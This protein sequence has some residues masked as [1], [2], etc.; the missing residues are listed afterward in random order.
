M[1]DLKK[2]PIGGIIPKPGTSK[3]LKT[4]DW[5]SERPVWIPKKCIQCMLCYVYCPENCIPTKDGKR[6]ATDLSYCKGCLICLNVCPTKA[7][8]HKE[9]EK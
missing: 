3:V 9:E 5:K 8:T 4:G 2:I 7:I 1:K 6:I